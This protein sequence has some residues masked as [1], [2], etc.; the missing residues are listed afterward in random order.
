MTVCRPHHL[1]GAGPVLTTRVC[2][3]AA[4]VNFSE[5]TFV[6][7]PKDP[8]RHT[9]NVRIF[10]PSGEAP[11]AGHPN[12]GTATVLAWKGELF[13]KPIGDT[14]AFEEIAGIV[15]MTIIRDSGGDAVG[16]TLVAPQRFQQ[17]PTAPI[18]AV[19]TALCIDESLI[20]T[21][22]HVPVVGSCGLPFVLAEL[23]D[24]AALEECR[25]AAASDPCWSILKQVLESLAACLHVEL[26]HTCAHSL[27]SPRIAVPR[28]AR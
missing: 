5:T 11:F 20:K 13:G 21:S 25:S 16:A 4:S 17:G 23:V 10:M 28:G 3:L 1:A 6:L 12:V 18:A 14:M 26:I 2:N 15:H 8:A 27:P 9:A 7:P 22:H 24:V 19:A